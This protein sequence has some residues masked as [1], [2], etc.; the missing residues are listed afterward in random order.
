MRIYNLSGQIVH[1][2]TVAPGTHFSWQPL[3]TEAG[4][5][6]FVLEGQNGRLLQQGKLVYMPE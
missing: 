1:Q 3:S 6:F 2:Q 4:F 5:Y